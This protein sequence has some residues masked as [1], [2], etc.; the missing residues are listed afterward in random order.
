MTLKLREIPLQQI[1]DYAAVDGLLRGRTRG[2]QIRLAAKKLND[3]I[4][5]ASAAKLL[6]SA[7]I[8]CLSTGQHIPVLPSTFRGAPGPRHGK[9]ECYREFWELAEQYLP[10]IEARTYVGL[11][12]NQIGQIYPRVG[13][14]LVC[15]REPKLLRWQRKYRRVFNLDRKK[16]QFVEGDIFTYLLKTASKPNWNIFDLDLMCKASEELISEVVWSVMLTAKE[17][18]PSIINLT[19]SIGRNITKNQY[20][21]LLP[22]KLLDKLKDFGAEVVVNQSGYYRDGHIPMAWEQVVFR[23]EKET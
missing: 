20:H 18:S 12:A 10:R 16:L 5:G 14:M 21:E 22:F 9:D 13:K 3:L 1:L 8:E 4:P 11:T 17:D 19:T 7:N 6:V 2:S 15:E 23:K